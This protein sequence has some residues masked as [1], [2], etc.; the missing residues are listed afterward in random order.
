VRQ[1]SDGGKKLIELK[2]LAAAGRIIEIDPPDTALA[3]A[4]HREGARRYLGLVRPELMAALR[5]SGGPITQCLAPWRAPM[6]AVRNSADVLIYRGGTSRYLWAF[7]RYRRAGLVAI[8]VRARRWLPAS[9]ACAALYTGLGLFRPAGW[10]NVGGARLLVLRVRR[11]ASRPSVRR[12]VSPLGGYPDLLRKL[13]DHQA[14]Y[15][16]LRWFTEHELATRTADEDLDVLVADEA[17]PTLDELLRE[18]PG[19]LPLDAYS[20]SGLPGSA[21]RAM[22]YYPPPLARRLLANAVELP[23][24]I[25]AP[26]PID[27]LHSLTFHALY[28][29]GRASGLNSTLDGLRRVS[30]PE[31]DYESAINELAADLDLELELDMESLDEYLAAQGWRPPTDTL[32]RLATKNAWVRTRFF[33]NQAEAAENDLTVFILRER[34]VD[35]GAVPLAV[36]LITALGFRLAHL[37]V[38]PRERRALAASAIRGGNWGRGPFPTSGGDPAAVVVVI[39]PHP[40]PVP[41]HLSSA[42]PQL[43]N[44]RTLAAKNLVRS[45]FNAT[46]HPDE[47]CN[48]LHSSDDGEQARDY[49]ATLLPDAQTTIDTAIARA[50]T[51]HPVPAGRAT[52]R[53]VRRLTGSGRAHVLK[54]RLSSEARRLLGRGLARIEDRLV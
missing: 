14:D 7:A 3:R 17:L 40:V 5:S 46:V 24:G 16:A 49:L 27:H 9:M 32:A 51:T 21:F 20:V 25:R 39:D 53:Q 28:H 54:R 43:A 35:D 2:E 41:G 38:L 4:L 11:R 18:E 12:Y 19:T 26:S 52:T 13:D 50:R 48:P 22:A 44:L 36:D 23:S 42:Y 45:R 6:E 15:V 10:L 31:H 47:R 8:E 29:K 30:D 1:W 34:L 37:E 33:P